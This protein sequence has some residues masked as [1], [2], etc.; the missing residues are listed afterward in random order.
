[1]NKAMW[2]FMDKAEGRKDSSFSNMNKERVRQGYKKV[3]EKMQNKKGKG[4]LNSPKRGRDNDVAL[5]KN[6]QEKS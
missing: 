3:A 5:G 4:S 6:E 1:M 2:D